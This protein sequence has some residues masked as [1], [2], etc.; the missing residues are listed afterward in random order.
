MAL[1]AQR[2]VYQAQL[3]KFQDHICDLFINRYVLRENDPGRDSIVIIIE[4]TPPE[5]R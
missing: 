5:G 3:Q 2:D 4:K 1:Q